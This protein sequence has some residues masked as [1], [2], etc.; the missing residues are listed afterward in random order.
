MRPT[1]PHDMSFWHVPHQPG[2]HALPDARGC[3]PF[4]QWDKEMR[5][6]SCEYIA[7]VGVEPTGTAEESWPQL[8]AVES[9]RDSPIHRGTPP[10]AAS[11]KEGPQDPKLS[12]IL[13]LLPPE[14][15]LLPLFPCILEQFVFF[16]HCGKAGDIFGIKS[17]IVAAGRCSFVLLPR[18]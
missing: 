9:P 15:Q 11:P 4:L 6:L 18:S 10:R 5:G 14:F 17:G 7:H 13:K 3:V 1:N 8:A 2:P 16:P 12:S